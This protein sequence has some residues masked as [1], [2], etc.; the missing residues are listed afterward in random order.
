[1]T[2][3]KV[4][5]SFGEI[6]TTEPP[7]SE[8]QCCSGDEVASVLVEVPPG[9][10]VIFVAKKSSKKRKDK[11][12]THGKP[13]AVRVQVAVEVKNVPGVRKHLTAAL[14]REA[15]MKYIETGLIRKV[16]G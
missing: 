12:K 2:A 10:C 3:T 15:A 5:T 7:S 11:R 8:K 4:F 6:L 14:L 16:S 13:D 9:H 1:V